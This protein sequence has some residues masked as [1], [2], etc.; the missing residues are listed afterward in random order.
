MR[1]VFTDGIR[2]HCID[3]RSPIDADQVLESHEHSVARRS[4][5]R[6]RGIGEHARRRRERQD[7]GRRGRHHGKPPVRP[8]AQ[9][10][11]ARG[12]KE[13]DQRDGERDPSGLDRDAEPEKAP[14]KRP[15]P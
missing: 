15:L 2:G 13:R 11:K 6:G 9:I 1:Q 12:K 3:E 8:D 14:H 5:G 10:E 4:A 7:E